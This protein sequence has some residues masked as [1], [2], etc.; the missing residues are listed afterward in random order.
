MIL[1]ACFHGSPHRQTCFCPQSAGAGHG[2]PPFRRW[3][4]AHHQ[5]ATAQVRDASTC[6][7]ASMLFD[8]SSLPGMLHA[9]AA[10]CSFACYLDNMPTRML[11]PSQG[12]WTTTSVKASPARLRMYAT[13]SW[14]LFVRFQQVGQP[15]TCEL[16]EEG[17][18]RPV[19]Y[20]ISGRAQLCET[21]YMFCSP[22][23]LLDDPQCVCRRLAPGLP[24][25]YCAFMLEPAP[26]GTNLRPLT[27]L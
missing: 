19:N 17:P 5:Q 11:L 20:Y 18:P 10:P 7:R 27:L 2:I 12:S 25:F 13:M 6:Q 3:P 14:Q 8:Q 1:S 26:P 15:G 23:L 24:V 16:G 21:L 22:N 9:C 4:Q